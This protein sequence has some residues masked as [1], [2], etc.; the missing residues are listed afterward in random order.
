MASVGAVLASERR[1]S[2]W[3]ARRTGD[4]GGSILFWSEM[5]TYVG[6]LVTPYK[7]IVLAKK[8]ARSATGFDHLTIHDIIACHDGPRNSVQ[9]FCVKTSKQCPAPADTG[10]LFRDGVVHETLVCGIA[11]YVLD[12]E[13]LAAHCSHDGVDRIGVV[14]DICRSVGGFKKDFGA[15][16]VPLEG[17]AGAVVSVD[18]VYLQ[19]KNGNVRIVGLPTTCV[20]CTL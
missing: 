10:I 12:A 16:R 18:I 13:K 17:R 20:C 5:P 9:D 11:D 2:V 15:N 3:M 14:V 8:P 6:Q 4:P 19:A 1:H 7:D